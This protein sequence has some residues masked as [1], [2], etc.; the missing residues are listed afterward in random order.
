MR[1]LPSTN[2]DAGTN[3]CPDMPLVMVCIHDSQDTLVLDAGLTRFGRH[4]GR[5]HGLLTAA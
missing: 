1:D 5:V 2:Y 3:T 4:P